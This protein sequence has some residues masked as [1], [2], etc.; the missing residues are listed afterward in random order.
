LRKL[1]PYRKGKAKS[2][3]D[4]KRAERLKDFRTVMKDKGRL[5]N[6]W[7]MGDEQRG[8]RGKGDDEGGERPKK[9]RKGKKER[10]KAREQQGQE[11]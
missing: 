9:K 3:W 4:E 11:D 8:K 2:G 10:M 7:A 1:A 5:R 6:G